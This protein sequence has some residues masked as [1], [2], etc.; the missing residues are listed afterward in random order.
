MII[1]DLSDN[2]NHVTLR[3]GMSG[4]ATQFTA[5]DGYIWAFREERANI[6]VAK[7][8]CAGRN[9]YFCYG[10]IVQQEVMIEEAQSQ[11]MINRLAARQST[12]LRG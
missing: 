4:N 12:C 5:R 6:N 8:P 3:S 2:P 7:A 9:A 10:S 1:V 11:R